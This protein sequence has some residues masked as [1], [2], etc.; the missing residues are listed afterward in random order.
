MTTFVYSLPVVNG[1]EDTWGET[2][3]TNWTNIGTFLGALDSAELAKLDGLTSSTAE[4]NILDGL[5]ASTA[6]LNILDGLT[7]ST[8]ELNIL[9]GL[10]ASTAELNHTDGV[11][12]NIQTQ[13]NAKALTA[14]STGQ[15]FNCSTLTVGNGASS[16]ISMFDSD[17]GARSIHCNSNRVGFLLQAGGWGSYCDDTGNWT[18]VGNVTAYSDRRLKSDIVTIPNALDTVSKLRGV[19]FT[20]DG[21][22]S[23]GVIAQ[24]VQ[25][26]MPEVVHEGGEYLSVAYGNLVGVLIEAVKELKAEVDA[27]KKV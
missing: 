23:T 2:L 26:V 27:L 4:L 9:D 8:A 19:N 25:E 6:E 17:Q 15:A 13:L 18:A 20:K 3:N 16:T 22:A 1:S 11:T 21:E 7:A 14:G 12:S 24:E 10:T 5:T